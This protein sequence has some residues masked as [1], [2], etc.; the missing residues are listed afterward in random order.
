MPHEPGS[1]VRFP[2]AARVM[3]GGRRC[4]F[5]AL[6]GARFDGGEV[7]G[8]S[9]QTL[10]SP[11]RGD[12]FVSV[13]QRQPYI[14]GVVPLDV[15]GPAVQLERSTAAPVAVDAAPTGGLG[16]QPKVKQVI[17]A[18]SLVVVLL[19]L[20]LAARVILTVSRSK[21]GLHGK[22]RPRPNR[23]TQ[24][25]PSAWEEA[26]RRLQVEAMPDADDGEDDYKGKR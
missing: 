15:T 26:G 7:V 14:A 6:I 5:P 1:R 4:C 8:C 12:L 21:L 2:G 10:S 19:I 9:R 20:L 11:R 17:S 3:F 13:V 22:R 23:K 18:G 25:P 16:L 24:T